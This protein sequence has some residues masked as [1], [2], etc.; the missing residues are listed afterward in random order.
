LL[1]EVFIAH[2][3]VDD[4]CSTWETVSALKSMVF[5]FLIWLFEVAD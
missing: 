5:P 1:A 3:D 4:D 2:T